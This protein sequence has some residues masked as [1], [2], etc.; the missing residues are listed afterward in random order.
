MLSRCGKN[1]IFNPI[2]ILNYPTKFIKCSVLT[3]DFS[4]HVCKRPTFI[5][6]YI[7][8]KKNIKYK[9]IQPNNLIREIHRPLLEGHGLVNCRCINFRT[10]FMKKYIPTRG[11][12]QPS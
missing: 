2:A 3:A 8:N 12:S 5:I 7:Y 11:K 4:I 10:I 6:K 1:D 9:T